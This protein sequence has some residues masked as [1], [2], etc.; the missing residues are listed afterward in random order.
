MLFLLKLNPCLFNDITRLQDEFVIVH[1]LTY[2]S[3]N[4]Q[5]TLSEEGEWQEQETNKVLVKV[6]LTPPPN[7]LPSPHRLSS[8]VKKREK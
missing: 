4:Q 6:A 1:I 7:I 5:Q 3:L 8:C 2:L